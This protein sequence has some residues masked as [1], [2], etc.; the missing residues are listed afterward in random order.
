MASIPQVTREPN[1]SGGQARGVHPFLRGARSRFFGGAGCRH[2][3]FTGRAIRAACARRAVRGFL[4]PAK[5]APAAAV[6]LHLR[7]R[8]VSKAAILRLPGHT[9]AAKKSK[10]HLNSKGL[11]H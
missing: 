3:S 8:Y 1:V 11:D 5:A 9:A 2:F 10:S 7:A 6:M 4:P